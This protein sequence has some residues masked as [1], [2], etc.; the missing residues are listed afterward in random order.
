MSRVRDHYEILGVSRDATSDQLRHAHRNL[1]RK[2]HP[3]HLTGGEVT[4]SARADAERRI[5]EVNVAW[6]VLSD[7]LSRMNYDL[8]LPEPR[9]HQARQSVAEDPWS[10]FPPGTEAE[11][12]EGFDE[13]FADTD[14]RRRGTRTVNPRSHP[15]KPLRARVLIGFGCILLMGI[16]LIVWVAGSGTGQVTP[17]VT[18]G[19]C[20]RIESG[21][22]ATVVP[23]SS[24][25]D[26]RVATFAQTAGKC[27]SG[28]EAR[29]LQAND[30]EVA[31]LV[32]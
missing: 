22:A 21:P 30:V 32:P 8:T 28:A 26:G 19:D 27:P 18:S 14:R 11:P 9:D 13:W 2:F 16:L 15:A 7:P 31:C 6:Q 3:D 20:V 10:P 23:C 5:R 25:N 29:R 17:G 12:S 24:P 1:A 4:S